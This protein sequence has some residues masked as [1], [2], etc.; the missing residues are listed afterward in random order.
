VAYAQ[1][2]WPLHDGSSVHRNSIGPKYVICSDI[3]FTNTHT[4]NNKKND[5][6]NTAIKVATSNS[7]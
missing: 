7:N 6:K 4:H 2:H 3:F 5:G 1:L